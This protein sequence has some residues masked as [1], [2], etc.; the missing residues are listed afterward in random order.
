MPDFKQSEI[1]SYLQ[2]CIEEGV[3]LPKRDEFSS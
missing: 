1:I 2:M 3:N